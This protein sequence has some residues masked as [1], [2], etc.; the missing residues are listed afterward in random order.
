[1]A[2]PEMSTQEETARLF[3]KMVV[4]TYVGDNKWKGSKDLLVSRGAVAEYEVCGVT[5][6][7]CSHDDL[8]T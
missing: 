7:R 6:N 4:F 3:Q 5:I 8:L 2:I 1:M